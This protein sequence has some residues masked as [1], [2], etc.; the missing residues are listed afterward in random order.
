MKYIFSLFI[1]L[2]LS[3]ICKAQQLQSP[4]DTVR[5]LSDSSGRVDSV[6]VPPV[7]P[8]NSD[9]LQAIRSWHA[10]SAI[11]RFLRDHAHYKFFNPPVSIPM[12]PRETKTNNLLFY[13]I[14][15]LIGFY[16]F[17]RIL[18]PRYVQNMFAV[19][20]RGN[21][22]AQQIREQMVQTPQA[23]LLLNLLFLLSAA[24]YLT[25]LSE[26]YKFSFSANFWMMYL[27]CIGFLTLVYMGKFIFLKFFGW[28][29]TISKATDAYIFIVF[30][31]NK[32]IGIF[33]LPVIVLLAFPYSGLFEA[34]LILSLILIIL[35]FLYRF[36]IS[37]RAVSKEIKVKR[38]QFFAYLCAF[39]IAPLLLIYKVLLN[40]M[41]S[42][43]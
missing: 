33:L 35:L 39:E 12:F 7:I 32:M 36:F 16:G 20:L 13:V 15:G 30:L 34:I 28:I 3:G 11:Q 43:T 4:V 40:L 10:I 18:F 14:V 24:L 23:S 42:I 31:T 9:S 26:Y 22:R 19:F 21:F 27:Y 2:F 29:F 6:V 5:I 8:L 17:I 37:Y 41:V 38:L 1:L 25:F